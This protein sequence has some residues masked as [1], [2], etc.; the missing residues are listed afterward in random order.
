M[1]DRLQS[2]YERDWSPYTKK[3]AQSALL[4]AIGQALSSRYEVPQEWPR[5][6]LALLMRLNA[7]HEV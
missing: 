6:M 2:S 3:T 5:E 4:S 7:Q 1:T